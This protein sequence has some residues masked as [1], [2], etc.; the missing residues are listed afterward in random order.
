MVERTLVPILEGERYLHLAEDSR[1]RELI[2]EI[3]DWLSVLYGQY[4]DLERGGQ[5]GIR[6]APARWS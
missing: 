6:R 5:V 3:D 2:A 4:M 1:A